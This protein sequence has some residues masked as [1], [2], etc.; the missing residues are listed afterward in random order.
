M[1]IYGH[2]IN[3][4]QSNHYSPI[5]LQQAIADL[6][7]FVNSK[8]DDRQLDGI[9]ARDWKTVVSELFAAMSSE[10][11]YQSRLKRVIVSHGSTLFG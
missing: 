11:A 8:R 5:P 6:R 3:F 4:F 9:D 1:I 2:I 10:I 7:V